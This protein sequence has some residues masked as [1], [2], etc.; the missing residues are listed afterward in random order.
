MLRSLFG[1]L[2]PLEEIIVTADLVS[3]MKYRKGFGAGLDV[4]E[5]ENYL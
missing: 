4:L 2:T 5:Y 3:A 1:C